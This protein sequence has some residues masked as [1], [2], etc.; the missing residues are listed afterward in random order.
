[1]N[2]YKTRTPVK[3]VNLQNTYTYNNGHL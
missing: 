3:H 1:M 2:K